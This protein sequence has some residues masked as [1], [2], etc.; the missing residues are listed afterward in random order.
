MRQVSSR[1]GLQKFVVEAAPLEINIRCSFWFGLLE[2]LGQLRRQENDG[3]IE[4][5]NV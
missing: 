1:E 4:S 5:E 3:H 2:L